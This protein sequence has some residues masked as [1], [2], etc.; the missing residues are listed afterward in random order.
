MTFIE[1]MQLAGLYL[2]THNNAQQTQD[3]KLLKFVQSV[4]KIF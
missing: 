2:R 4:K 3:K 1:F